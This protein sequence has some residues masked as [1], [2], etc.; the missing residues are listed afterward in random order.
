MLG[1]DEI[2]DPVKFNMRYDGGDTNFYL[3]LCDHIDARIAAFKAAGIDIDDYLGAEGAVADDSLGVE[4]AA[5]ADDYL[6]AEGA[7]ADD[8]LGAEGSVADDSKKKV[9]D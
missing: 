2:N 4:G 1:E 7:V 5:V 3:A 6:G 9:E 8:S